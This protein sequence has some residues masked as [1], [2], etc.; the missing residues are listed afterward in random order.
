MEESCLGSEGIYDTHNILG[1]HDDQ[2]S[3]NLIGQVIY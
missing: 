2:V 1:I 3:E